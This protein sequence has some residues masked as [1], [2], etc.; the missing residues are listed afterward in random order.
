MAKTKVYDYY[1]GL[2]PWA[3]GVAVVGG[4]IVVTIVGFK[5]YNGIKSAKANNNAMLEA[6]KAETD[7]SY[8]MS[9]GIFPKYP[10]SQYESW[11][12]QLVS[13]FTGCGVD[14]SKVIAVFQNMV[15]DADVLKLVSQY[16]VRPFN[17]C[18]SWVYV[19]GSGQNNM[20]LSAAIAYKMSQYDI[21]QLNSVLAQRQINYRF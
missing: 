7:L 17:K 18:A 12:N 10:N 9:H 20:T 2:P 11:S 8:Y 15:N 16:G 21:D 4:A 1:K 19:F 13:A 5:I 14:T 3:K 6:A